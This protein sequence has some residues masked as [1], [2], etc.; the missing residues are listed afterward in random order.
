MWHSEC[1]LILIPSAPFFPTI[2]GAPVPPHQP[3]LVGFAWGNLTEDVVG[4]RLASLDYLSM[5]ARP[6]LFEDGHGALDRGTCPETAGSVI[7]VQW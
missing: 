2:S 4:K 3:L 1:D 6:E 5:I 7:A